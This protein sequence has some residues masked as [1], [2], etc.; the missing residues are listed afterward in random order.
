MTGTMFALLGSMAAAPLAA[1]ILMA[2][3]S[4]T[5]QLQ[6]TTSDVLCVLEAAKIDALT[7]A[8][9]GI[10]H[11]VATAPACGAPVPSP[12]EGLMSR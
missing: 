1:G 4:A 9:D 5:I 8:P 7:R 6:S 2:G 3:S 11:P 12:E 10:P